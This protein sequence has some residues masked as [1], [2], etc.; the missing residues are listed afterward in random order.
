MG[1][2]QTKIQKAVL[3]YRKQGLC[4]VEIAEKVGRKPFAICEISRRIG[5]PFT[6]EETARAKRIGYDKASETRIMK[7]AESEERR[8]HHAEWVNTYH[9][10]WEWVSGWIFL[11]AQEVTIKN[12]VCGHTAIFSSNTVRKKTSALNCPICEEQEKARRAEEREKAKEAERQAAEERK[13][14]EKEKKTE[15]FWGQDFK[16]MSITLC[17]VCGCMI[18]G[19]RKKYCSQ[20]CSDTVRNAVTKDKRIK[21]MKAGRRDAITLKQVYELEEGICYICGKKCDFEDYERRD[22][23][24]IAGNYYP[25][26]EHIVPLSKGGTH[27][28]DNVRLAHRICNTL[29]GAK[30]AGL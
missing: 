15:Q 3:E 1:K 18:F 26:V 21:K 12:V 8:K 13:R 24:F 17:P 27:T 2:Y 22:G 6:E 19:R 29:K 23:A 30:V 16:Q 4:S 9:P 7:N 14:E 28:W 11:D 20:K 25:S 10:E 5:M